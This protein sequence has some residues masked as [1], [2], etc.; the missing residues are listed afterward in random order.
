MAF[1]TDSTQPRGIALFDLDGTL[2]PWD[3]QVLFCHRVLRREGWR[4]FYLPVFLLFVPFAKVLGA[5]GLKRVFLSYLWRM[6]EAELASHAR[7]FA[8]ELT[9]YPELVAEIEHHR[10]KGN[11]LVLTSASPEF[12]V[13][14]IGKRLG[15]HL[16]LG[17]PVETEG[18]VGFFPD[19][20]NH[21]G[22]AKV[23]RLR[24]LMPERFK[25]GHLKNSHG[26]TDSTAD[27][28]LLAICKTATLVNPSAELTDLGRKRGWNITRPARP[29]TSKLDRCMRIAALVTGIGHDPAA[30]EKR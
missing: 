7:A 16:S 12:Y 18:G 4:R 9:F 17:T 13:G 19:L 26:Y 20:D 22:S 23:D 5:A 1:P 21:K 6:P 8:Q 28:P 30:L 27:L 15:F 10:S 29:W 24:E 11:L 14:E 2:L 25:D 3:C